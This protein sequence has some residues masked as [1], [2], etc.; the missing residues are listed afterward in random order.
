LLN[1]LS[2]ASTVKDI[3]NPHLPFRI[4]KFKENWENFYQEDLYKKS[5][6]NYKEF[7]EFCR[8]A[9]ELLHDV[10]LPVAKGIRLKFKGDE[11][12]G[13]PGVITGAKQGENQEEKAPVTEDVAK[14]ALNDV[15][16]QNG[17]VLI[18]YSE[19]NGTKDFNVSFN[20]ENAEKKEHLEGFTDVYSKYKDVF[21]E[22]V[23]NNKDNKDL[24][25]PINIMKI[26]LG[27][28]NEEKKEETQEKSKEEV[29]QKITEIEKKV[30]DDLNSLKDINELEKLTA[31]FI[32]LSKDVDNNYSA[33]YELN[34][35]NLDTQKQEK[36][37]TQFKDANHDIFNKML[38]INLSK[39]M[40]EVQSAVYNKVMFYL[41]L[42]SEENGEQDSYDKLI[43]V[44]TKDIS[45]E[46]ID[47]I[48]EV[49]NAFAKEMIEWYN[50][51][52]DEQKAAIEKF[53]NDPL[54][55]YLARKTLKKPKE[56][57][58]D[59]KPKEEKNEEHQE[60]SGE[61]N[62]ES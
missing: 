58:Q 28:N 47:K 21:E 7:L 53:K 6:A 48:K 24:Q 32:E 20:K 22:W 17:N 12:A 15:K 13:V 29:R 43:S 57:N 25:E 50:S 31:Q 2:R 23:K 39:K 18:R 38:Y 61:N 55:L 16:Y 49:Y 35:T 45:L 26:A 33:I 1:W 19:Y 10:H 14:A 30:N 54:A 60:K 3:K 34:K 11:D 62:Q 5:F 4:E 46:N 44:L 27:Y 41:L 59:E 8:N 51:L 37:N 56:E 36:L 40:N 52:N 42:E 9:Q